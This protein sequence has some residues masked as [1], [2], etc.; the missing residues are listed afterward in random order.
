MS[1]QPLTAQAFGGN[2]ADYTERIGAIAGVGS[3]KI[4]P[5]W[6]GEGT[7][8]AIIT[9]EAGGI[10]DPGLVAQVQETVDGFAPIGHTVT[11]VAVE[12]VFLPIN[13]TLSYES[14]ADVEEV[15]T[16][17]MD[18]LVDRFD[19]IR[20]A[21]HNEEESVIRI[22]KIH[23]CILNCAGVEGVTDLTIGG[24]SENLVLSAQQLPELG[25]M[26]FA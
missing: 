16:A 15:Q 11:V 18:A 10:P 26:V 20:Q 19:L 9:D 4:L 25:E 3:V 14:G 2:R 8:K 17:V 1:P 21:W 22:S 24:K 5:A 13:A 12:P 7:V 23:A 6:N